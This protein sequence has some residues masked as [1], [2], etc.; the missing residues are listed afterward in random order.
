[1]V[2]IMYSCEVASSDTDGLTR[3]IAEQV[4]TLN[5]LP[6]DLIM[7]SGEYGHTRKSIF[8]S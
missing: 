3:Q 5:A 7:S 4:D 2:C 1:M 8:D 6:I